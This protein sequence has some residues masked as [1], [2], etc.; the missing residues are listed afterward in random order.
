VRIAG[1]PVGSRV[2]IVAGGITQ[3]QEVSG[4]Y[5]H[6]GIQNESV[7]HFGLGGVCLVDSIHAQFPGGATKDYGAYA[8][9]QQLV[10]SR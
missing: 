2:E 7:L 6:F 10:L 3:V 8:G 4:G 9:N 5:G 1:L